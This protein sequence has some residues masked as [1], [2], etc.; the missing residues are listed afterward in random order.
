[1]L[2]IALGLASSLSW[3]VSDFIGGLQSRRMP[4]LSVLLV[5]QP[6]GLV[7]ALTLALSSG[8]SP[9]SGGQAA[10]AFAG[11]AA[12]VLALACF[13]LAMA[14]G[15]ISIVTP[16]ASMGAIVPVAVGLAR[17]ESPSSIQA[18]GL[19]VALAGI[20][21]AVREVED[22]DAASVPLRSI[23]LAALAGL[24]FGAFFVAM[25]AAAGRDALW[26][27]AFARSGG[28]AL[29][30]PALLVSLRLSPGSLR[31]PAGVLPL[32]LVIGFLDIL[33][34][35]LFGFATREGLLALVAVAGSLYPVATVLLARFVLGERLASAQKAG[36][37][38]A[39][40]GA[41]ML[42]AGG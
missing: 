34:N 16:V 35:E 29:I 17:G 13:Y 33:A 26:A 10:T 23:V 31:F 8:P 39:L 7:L 21:L 25:D 40:S 4:V 42:A 30:V 15:A 5:S 2:G 24:G 37:A 36:V 28:V 6:V 12:G 22:P 9:L 27:T 41:V 3:G 32:L 20:V 19:V 14:S 1:V 38:L 11:G 18:A